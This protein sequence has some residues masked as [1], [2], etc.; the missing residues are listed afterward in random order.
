MAISQESRERD[1]GLVRGL[2]E[3][4][5]SDALNRA[6]LVSSSLN[7]AFRERS[8]TRTNLDFFYIFFC[9]CRSSTPSYSIFAEVSRMMVAGKEGGRKGRVKMKRD[10]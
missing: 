3:V 5:W 4:T 1:L 9:L 2:V 7:S 10:D 6:A 8:S